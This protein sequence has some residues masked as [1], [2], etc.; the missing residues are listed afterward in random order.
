MLDRWEDRSDEIRSLFNPA[1]CSLLLIRVTKEFV[2]TRRKDGQTV[3]GLPFSLACLVLPIILT[4]TIRSEFPKSTRT[5]FLGWLQDSPELLIGFGERV[6]AFLDITR[7]SIRFAC[8]AGFLAIDENGRI[9][10]V[11]RKPQGI[12]NV[13]TGSDE[14]QDCFKRSDEL[15]R[16]LSRMPNATV[17]YQALRIRP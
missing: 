8:A 2:A 4:G 12:G 14:V 7:E 3:E 11:A 15:G 13:S 1:F 9:V 17:V 6:R 16:Q 10:G 5:S